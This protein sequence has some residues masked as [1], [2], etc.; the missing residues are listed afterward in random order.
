MK[1]PSGIMSLYVNMIC[2][3][4]TATIEAVPAMWREEVQAEVD[5]VNA[6]NEA[7][8]NEKLNALE[9]AHE[10][11][12]SEASDTDTEETE[13]KE[14]TSETEETETTTVPSEESSQN[15]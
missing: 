9:E 2:Y 8:I 13:E 12:A 11:L 6:E 15:T 7:K 1:C 10:K 5:R 4:H 3:L 14:E